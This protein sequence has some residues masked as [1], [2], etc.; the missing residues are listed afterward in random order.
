[1]IVC[2]ES[3]AIID[4]TK[5]RVVLFFHGQMQQK[6]IEFMNKATVQA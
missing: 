3:I 2:S 6:D 1:M 4:V 5:H